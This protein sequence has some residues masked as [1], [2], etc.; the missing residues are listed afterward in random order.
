MHM[1]NVRMVV[2]GLH[3]DCFVVIYQHLLV[4]VLQSLDRYIVYLDL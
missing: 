1:L 4:N 2:I 3:L